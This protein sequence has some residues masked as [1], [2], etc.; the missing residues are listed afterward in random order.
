M[1]HDEYFEKL[2]KVAHWRQQPTEQVTTQQKARY[3]KQLAQLLEQD[4]EDD[5]DLVAEKERLEF[6][7]APRRNWT[8]PIELLGLKTEERPCEDCGKLV[9]DRTV[10]R[11]LL[12][13]PVD[14]WRVSCNLCKM[15]QNPETGK[16]TVNN[17]IV[18]TFFRDYFLKRNK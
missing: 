9:K 17:K 4:W 14:H 18:Q 15:S 5:P 13:S 7:V 16:F 12:T 1:K 2:S 3:R 10:S 6:L 11:K 8:L